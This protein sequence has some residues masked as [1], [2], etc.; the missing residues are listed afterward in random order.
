[1]NDENTHNQEE[2]APG[3]F[4]LPG[5]YFQKSAASL[6]NRLEWEEEHRVY[7]RLKE[8]KA[9]TGFI[10]PPSY[11]ER[12]GAALEL[13]EY[14]T[15]LAHPKQNNFAV[16]TDYF[17]GLS[18]QEL[19]Q[20]DYQRLNTLERKNNF[21]LP[22]DYFVTKEAELKNLLQTNKPVKV[23]SLL[24][25]SVTYMAA[26]VLLVV[27]SMWV[28]SAYFK[29][30]DVKDCGSIACVD[31]NDLLKTKTLEVLDNEELYELVNPAELEKNLETKP[32]QQKPSVKLDT[33]L[34]EVGVEDLL[35]EI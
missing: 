15:L 33:G 24:R 1:M 14:P 2:K 11:F 30:A 4:G 29:P 8:L 12:S 18:L 34:K 22:P 19:N 32:Q 31:R 3:S 17:E 23:I 13:L 9:G 16:P 7:P 20:S 21:A 27:I 35:D 26:A 5:G 10:T 6:L 25:R 28:Y